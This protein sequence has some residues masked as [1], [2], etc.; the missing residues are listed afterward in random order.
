VYQTTFKGRP[1]A[2]KSFVITAGKESLPKLHKVCGPAIEL[3]VVTQSEFKL[4]AR[5]VVGWKWLQHEN[6]LPFIGVTPKFAI[7]SDLMENGT[8][9][10]FITNHPRHN[11]LHLVSNARA[12]IRSI[13]PNFCVK[14]M[15]AATGLEYLHGRNIIHGDL[16][17]VSGHIRRKVWSDLDHVKVNILIDSTHSARLADFGLAMIIDESTVGSTTGGHGP[18]G[19]TRWMAPEI[20]YP[21]HFGF[22]KDCR[23]RLPSTST[24]IYALGMTILEVRAPGNDS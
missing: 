11:R 23:R 17:G 6:I 22:S 16:K 4:L 21:E 8:I 24:D 18:R 14:L 9:M 3:E 2:V 7:V 15:G 20:L 10:D 1:V 5:E 13:L 19:T 12:R